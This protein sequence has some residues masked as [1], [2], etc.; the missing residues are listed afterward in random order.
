MVL[1]VRNPPLDGGER[2]LH[3]A[4]FKGPSASPLGRSSR[5]GSIWLSGLTRWALFVEYNGGRDSEKIE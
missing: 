2:A 3:S 5:I 4:D 1:S